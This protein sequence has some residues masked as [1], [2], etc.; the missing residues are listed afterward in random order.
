MPARR[1]WPS[2]LLIAERRPIAIWQWSRAPTTR[3]MSFG[4]TCR[5]AGKVRMV[6]PRACLKPLASAAAS[7]V[8]PPR[9]RTISSGSALLQRLQ[10]RQGL[11]IAP[12][13]HIDELV[14]AADALDRGLVGAMG[15]GE[16]RLL[17]VDRYHDRQGDGGSGSGAG[18]A[19]SLDGMARSIS[20]ARRCTAGASARRRSRAARR[21]AAMVIRARRTALAD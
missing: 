9:T 13:Q 11:G 15:L 6:S 8:S 16:I 17:A 20:F 12:V 19:A 4:S 1:R 14:R 2:V 10:G 3:G 5:W 7:P 18:V 21:P